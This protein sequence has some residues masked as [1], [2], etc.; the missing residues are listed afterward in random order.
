[1][2][3]ETEMEETGPLDLSNWKIVVVLI[4]T[5]FREGWMEKEYYWQDMAILT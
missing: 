3:T 1:M 4:Q 2:E 5:E